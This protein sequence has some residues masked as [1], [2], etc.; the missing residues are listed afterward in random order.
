[1]SLFK[2]RV[3]VE[4]FCRDSYENIYLHPKV[5]NKDVAY[6]Y[7]G[8]LK[9]LLSEADEVFGDISEEKFALEIT[10][11]QFELFALAWAHELPRLALVQSIFTKQYSTVQGRD[12]IWETMHYY[13]DAIGEGVLHW[14]H[15]LGKV[16][17]NFWYGMRNDLSTKNVSS[18][19]V[20]SM[21]GSGIDCATMVNNRLCSENAWGQSILL[22]GLL[23]TVCERLGLNA[24]ALTPASTRGLADAMRG[25]YKGA[26]GMM[27]LV[28]ITDGGL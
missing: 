24:D 13:N 4:S 21:G 3:T 8:T 19:A 7:P 22:Q 15:G 5:G 17:Q 23:R 6:V 2:R 25:T 12:D 1:M 14:L 27:K 11:L 18:S 28:K 16:N 10:S 9:K 26:L 20:M